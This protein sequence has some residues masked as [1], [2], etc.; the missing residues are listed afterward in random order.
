MGVLRRHGLSQHVMEA[1]AVELRGCALYATD[2]TRASV[3]LPES[4]WGLSRKRLD[5]ILLAEAVAAGAGVRQPARFEGLEAGVARVRNLGENRVDSVPA[6][7][8]VVADGK[9]GIFG[10]RA[11]TTGQLGLKAHFEGVV[12]QPGAIELFGVR[13]HYGGVSPI[14]GGRWNTAFSVPE[15]RV[16][17]SRGDLDGL[18]A[19]ILAE[20]VTLAEKF[21]NARRAGTW[22]AS[23]LPRFGV[24]RDWPAGVVPVGNAA[25]AIEPIGG[26][27]MGLAMASGEMAAAALIEAGEDRGHGAVEAL[28]RDYRKLWNRRRAACRL[29]AI[30]LSS[31]TVSRWG[32][33]LL[34]KGRWVEGSVLEAL[35]KR[36]GSRGD[37][38]PTERRGLCDAPCNQ[39]G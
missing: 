1:G 19:G 35:G 20:N 7:W 8:V 15:S 32:L 24:V 33:R 18:F 11:A 38:V 29:G 21:R 12:G 39:G 23:P 4:M 37:G 31:P 27:G 25:A 28:G 30:V 6:D 9:G 17:A 26:E 34:G 10:D 16:R 3:E 22:M 5:P 13:G 14:E 2:G 36:S